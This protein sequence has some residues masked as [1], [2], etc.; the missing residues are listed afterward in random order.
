MAM[1]LRSVADEKLFVRWSVP[2]ASTLAICTS[3]IPTCR[4]GGTVGSHVGGGV[5]VAPPEFEVKPPIVT[6]GSEPSDEP[7]SVEES[8]APVTLPDV[9]AAPGA[10][11]GRAAPPLAVVV[12]PGWT[13]GLV[14]EVPEDPVGFVAAVAAGPAPVPAAGAPGDP[15]V[16]EDSELATAPPFWGLPLQAPSETARARREAV[17]HVLLPALA[18]KCVILVHSPDVVP[19][20]SE[21]MRFRRVEPSLSP[22]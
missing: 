17:T 11:P 6:E 1:I 4:T 2:E 22:E 16:P 8:A 7:G 5:G 14:A 10:D 12:V 18:P 9:E 21:G 15:A 13:A 19:R 3:V 20:G